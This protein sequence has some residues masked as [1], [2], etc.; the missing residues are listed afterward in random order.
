M[1]SRKRW[2]QL[3]RATRERY[4]RAGEAYGLT[5]RSVRERYNRGTM[6]PGSHNPVQR[7]PREWRRP[8]GT[9]GG[10]DVI[11]AGEAAY[12]NVRRLMGDYLQFDDANLREAIRHMSTAAQL[13][14]ANATEDEIAQW[15]KVQN[16]KQARGEKFPMDWAWYDSDGNWHNIWW[17]H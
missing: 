8:P 4:A 15:A 6:N 11:N 16:A 3:S 2:G 9:G 5:R 12:R 7:V 10:G 1:A 14:L 17:Y 13:A